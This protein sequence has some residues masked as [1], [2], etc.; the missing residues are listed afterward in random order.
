MSCS[1]E[2]PGIDRYICWG[3]TPI[4]LFFSYLPLH[5]EAAAHRR[6]VPFEGQQIPILG[7]LELAVFKAPIHG[8]AA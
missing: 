8:I 4:D 3:G 1:G 5:D 7:P 2:P 6:K